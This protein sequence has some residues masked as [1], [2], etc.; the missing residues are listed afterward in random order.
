LLARSLGGETISRDAA[1]PSY[2]G[3]STTDF[4]YSKDWQVVAEWVNGSPTTQYFWSP[5]YFDSLILRDQGGIR[6]YVHQDAKFK[7]PV[8]ISLRSLTFRRFSSDFSINSIWELLW[9]GDD[10]E[11]R[12]VAR[13]RH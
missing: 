1:R 9:L 12:L 4:F 13:Y 2:S 6:I 10:A 8:I 11:P 5:V 3:T 7:T